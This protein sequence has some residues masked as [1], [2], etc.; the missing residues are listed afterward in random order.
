M[1]K[2]LNVVGSVIDITTHK[3]YTN[4]KGKTTPQHIKLHFLF[5]END[6]R[7]SEVFT[8]KV[9][10]TDLEDKTILGLLNK[11]VRIEDIVIK[12][13]GDFAAYECSKNDITTTK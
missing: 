5:K 2:I 3:E 6:N 13:S 4:D 12:G 9:M 10:D 8:V 1:K 11:M 7:K